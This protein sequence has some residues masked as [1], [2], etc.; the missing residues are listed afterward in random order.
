MEAI[1]RDAM[2]AGRSPSRLADAMQEEW[3]LTAL[4]NLAEQLRIP[5][6]YAS[7]A[8]EELPGRGG[9]CVIHGERRIIIERTLTTREKARLLATGLAQFDLE[10][11]FLLPAVREA[12][13]R[14]KAAQ[15]QFPGT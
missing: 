11:V 2:E 3:L 5:V 14:A 12:I 10:D 13:E 9:L 8:T 15:P 6:A 7:L 1:R 4:E